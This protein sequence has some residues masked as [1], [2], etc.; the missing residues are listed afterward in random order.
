MKY[1]QL[2]ILSLFTVSISFSQRTESVYLNAKDSTTNM[3][4]AVFPDKEII[5]TLE[6]KIS[7]KDPE[8]E[9]ILEDVKSKRQ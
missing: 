4:V 7:N 6:D 9:W 3:Y 8:L 2:L 1:F 5:P